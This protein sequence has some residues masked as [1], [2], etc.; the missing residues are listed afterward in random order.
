LRLVKEKFPERDPVDLVMTWVKELAATKIF[1]SKEPNVLGSGEF[2][3][4]H[5]SVFKGLLE[6]LTPAEI[7]S[8]ISL[9][10][11]A[12]VTIALS[13]D[14]LANHLKT[15]PLFRSLLCS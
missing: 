4:E 10:R 7:K 12:D 6:G 5:L 1:G 2:T 11:Q 3:A 9:T 13:I 8:R 15:L 14:D